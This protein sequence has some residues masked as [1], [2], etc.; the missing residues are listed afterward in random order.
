MSHTVATAE[1]EGPLGVLLELVESSR[2]EVS[3]ISVGEITSRYL[4]H[5]RSLPVSAQEL[6][7]F[8][9]L[10]ARLLY[11][12]TLALLPQTDPEKQA[13]ELKQL[14]IELA[15]YRRF[16]AAAKQLAEQARYATWPRPHAV[17][18]SPKEHPFPP[19]KLEQLSQAF[20]DILKRQTP[21]PTTIRKQHINLETIKKRLHTLLPQGF[22]LESVTAT[23]QSRLEVVVT[24]LAILELIREGG[25]R[26]SQAGQFGAIRLEAVRG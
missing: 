24:F 7:E 12:K 6:N 21:L 4:K 17:Q 22:E 8:L 26:V 2:V 13:S 14:S 9:Q 3:A 20:T 5:V 19:L 23:C 18:L 25:V 11:I 10:G 1:F 16:Q 15:D